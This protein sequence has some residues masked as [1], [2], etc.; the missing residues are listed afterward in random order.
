MRKKGKSPKLQIGWEEKP[1]RIL[2]K[3]NEVLVQNQR[4]GGTKKRIVH[5]NRIRR[6]KDPDKVIPEADN[7]L[8]QAVVGHT[9]RMVSAMPQT[10]RT[11]FAQE[12]QTER[13]EREMYVTNRTYERKET[14][15][16]SSERSERSHR[17][18]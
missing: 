15:E 16:R 3:I 2:R 8:G 17:T 5:V 18:S 13:E 7:P 1:Y 14:Y 4:Q 12:R 11:I 6:V 9:R 10:S